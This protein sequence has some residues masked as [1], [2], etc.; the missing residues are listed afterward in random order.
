MTIKL[1]TEPSK[2]IGGFS[3]QELILYG[4]TVTLCLSIGS[5]KYFLDYPAYIDQWRT[6]LV[7]PEKVAELG[8]NAYGATHVLFA[9]IYSISPGAPRLAFSLIWL[10]G[11][12]LLLRR[13][14]TFSLPGWI[15]WSI[16]IFLYLNPYF[17]RLYAYGQNDLAVSGMLLIAVM[18]HR[19]RRDIPAGLIF[20]LALSYKFYPIVAIPFLVFDSQERT[21][22][23]IVKRI[24]WKFLLSVAAMTVAL[25][26]WTYIKMGPSALA[27]YS[28]LATRAATESSLAYFATHILGTN[29]LQRLG[30]LPGGIAILLLFVAFVKL[31]WS[32]YQSAIL[33]LI[34]LFIFS[35]VFYYVYIIG[36]VALVFENATWQSIHDKPSLAV[37]IAPVSYMAMM[38]GVFFLIEMLTRLQG[39][40]LIAFKGAIY[41][42]TN[43]LLSILIIFELSRSDDEALSKTREI[44]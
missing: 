33:A 5:V 9:Y 11:G 4:F 39:F 12:A 30:F 32:Q 38:L 26:I 6:I 19:D 20:A 7:A 35:P 18:C 25:L 3:L 31:R 28:F 15:G 1:L 41:A 37:W 14:R 29:A 36:T 22:R 10:L 13:C 17:L 27:P 24:R 34:A 23:G 42:V 8:T 40:P 21:D 16:L 43:V 44:Y 2:K